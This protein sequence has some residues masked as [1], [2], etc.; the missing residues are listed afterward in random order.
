MTKSTGRYNIK[1]VLFCV[2]GMMIVVCLFAARAFHRVDRWH[3]S[4][5]NCSVDSALCLHHRCVLLSISLFSGSLYYTGLA[6]GV[7]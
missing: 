4:T 3:T 2:T 6:G 7:K 1:P 5:A